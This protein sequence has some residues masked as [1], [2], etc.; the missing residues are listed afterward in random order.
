[1]I[2]VT[3]VT[4]NNCKQ[5]I[6]SRAHHDYRHCKCGHTSVDGGFEYI[7]YGWETETGKPEQVEIE[8][9]ATKKELYDDWN[10][11]IDKYGRIDV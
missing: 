4:C 3:G 6:Y 8:V 10:R 1:M 9:D 11:S 2:K 7:R 5:V